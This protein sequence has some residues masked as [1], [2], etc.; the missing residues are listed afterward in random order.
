MW[1]LKLTPCDYRLPLQGERILS[2][3]IIE[4]LYR[5]AYAD[6]LAMEIE[7]WNDMKTIRE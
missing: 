2:I 3:E 5:Y 7:S 1:L 6:R 4:R